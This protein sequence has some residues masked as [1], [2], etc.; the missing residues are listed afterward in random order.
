MLLEWVQLIRGTN[1]SAIN[2]FFVGS[3]PGAHKEAEMYHWGH[4]KVARILCK[5]AVLPPDAPQWP[6]IAQSS[7]I[8]SLGPSVSDWITTDILSSL[9][10]EKNK[11]VKSLPNFKFIYPSIMNY[12]SS[13]DFKAG[14]SCLPY[15][16][17]THSKQEW[18]NNHLQ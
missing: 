17:K 2:V 9:S 5:N 12:K 4:K 3:V 15:S 14:T 18:L 10:Q 8:G 11:G 13:F 7:S 1:C 6:V 16:M